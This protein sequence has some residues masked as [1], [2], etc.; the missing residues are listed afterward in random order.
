MCSEWRLLASYRWGF[1]GPSNRRRRD[2]AFRARRRNFFEAAL[3]EKKPAGVT[4][5]ASSCDCRLASPVPS[6]IRFQ[7][8]IGLVN[9][10]LT[11]RLR[12]ASGEVCQCLRQ[13]SNRSVSET[14]GARARSGDSGSRLIGRCR[15][16]FAQIS[17]ISRKISSMVRSLS[18]RA[19][20]TQC[21]FDFVCRCSNSLIQIKRCYLLFRRLSRGPTCLTADCTPRSAF[22]TRSER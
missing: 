19:M 2:T 20:I 10:K 21:G 3:P 14:A 1:Q 8:C 17:R 18:M 4:P 13:T 9:E 6:R 16:S 11:R 7:A 5:S 12:G 15:S 22:R